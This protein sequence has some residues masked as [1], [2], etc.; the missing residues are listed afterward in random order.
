[1]RIENPDKPFSKYTCY[2]IYHKK[3][4]RW[5]VHYIDNTPFKNRRT[6][7]YAKF[8]MS[9]KEGRILSKD[10]EVDH[11]NEDK[12]DD[13]IENLQIISQ[14]ENLKKHHKFSGRRS[15]ELVCAYCGISFV[16]E[17]RLMTEKTNNRFCSRR[18][19]GKYTTSNN[20]RKKKTI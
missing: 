20:K 2:K 3:Q 14:K 7:T 8:L 19:N 5:Y 16:K 6:I 17:N 11:I 18:C 10:E 9:I 13:R 4:K 12:S 1:M 15:T